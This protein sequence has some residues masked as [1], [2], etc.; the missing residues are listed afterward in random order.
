MRSPGGAAG[1]EDGL[2]W[3]E[4]CGWQ[5]ARASA[6][7]STERLTPIERSNRSRDYGARHRPNLARGL[8]WR[9]WTCSGGNRDAHK[10][11]PGLRIV[12][13]ANLDQRHRRVMAAEMPPVRGTDFLR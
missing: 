12:E 3:A 5:A 13:I 8:P 11:D 4:A 1:D 9:L 10:L 6:I 7:R 2:T